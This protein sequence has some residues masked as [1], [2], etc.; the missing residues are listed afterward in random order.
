[1]A[2]DKLKFRIGIVSAVFAVCVLSLPVLA[3]DDAGDKGRTGGYIPMDWDFNVQMTDEDI[4]FEEARERIVDREDDKGKKS[5]LQILKVNEYTPR[6]EIPSNYPASG[7]SDTDALKTALQGKFPVLRNQAEFGTCWAHAS[8]AMAEFFGIEHHFTGY[9]KYDTDFSELYLALAIYEQRQNRKIGLSDEGGAITFTGNDKE[10]ID[11]GG[12]FTFA[13]QLLSKGFG[14]VNETV[15][16]YISSKGSSEFGGSGNLTDEE[17]YNIEH[18]NDKVVCHLT[19]LY[20]VDIGSDTGKNIVKEAIMQ[21]GIVGLSMYYPDSVGPY[22]RSFGNG[23]AF[24]YDGVI[25]KPSKPGTQTNHAVCIVGWD[26]D[27]PKSNFNEGRQPSGN[28]AWLIRNSWWSKFDSDFFTSSG[29]FWMSY[30]D[31]CLTDSGD[32]SKAVYIY[33]VTND[34]GIYDNV[35][36]YDKQIHGTSSL[37]GTNTHGELL[38]DLN[39]YS[40]NVFA[41]PDDVDESLKEVCIE[42][43]SATD[44]EIKIYTDIT[45]PNDPASGTLQN[46]ATTTGTLSFPGIYTIPLNNPVEL[47]LGTSFSVVVITKENSVCYEIDISSGQLS[48]TPGIKTG[49]SFYK[50][51]GV[52]WED[53]KN[54]A[55]GNFCISAHTKNV[56]THTLVAG[57]FTF[58]K[59]SVSTYDG[60]SHPAT[61]TTRVNAGTITVYYSEDGVEWTTD[62]PV[63]PGT[64]SVK[65]DAA[66]SEKVAGVSGLTDPGWTFT[67][68]KGKVTV[69]A[70]DKTV[71]QGKEMPSLTYSVSGFNG[72]PFSVKPVLSCT[73]SDTKTIGEYKIEASGGTFEHPERF[74]NEIEYEDGVLTI[75]EG[76]NP[77]EEGGKEDEKEVLEKQVYTD[78][79]GGSIS[80]IYNTESH[81][82]ETESGEQVLGVSDV[83]GNSFKAAGYQYTGKKITPGKNSLV[84]YKG[85]VYRF[86]TD[87]TVSFKRN[88]KIGS[89]DAVIKWKKTSDPYLEGEKKTTRGFEIK[90]REVTPEMVQI[91]NKGDKIK[92]ITVAA[93]G[94]TIKAT[95][96]DYYYTGTEADGFEITFTNNFN[97]KVKKKA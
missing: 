27:F 4:S 6:A 16:P 53:K 58:K 30:E 87:Y 35:Y 82:L 77:E 73:A 19:N 11:F 10:R 29:Y 2:F 39:W 14:Y 20:K 17:K 64:Y 40:A 96:K 86:K 43:D 85:V 59:P 25:V 21:N 18:Y 72:D 69:K 88:K 9:S 80:V 75:T 76:D 5:D 55:G 91:F 7:V 92:K 46:S 93:D 56:G 66:G 36:Y 57:D 50:Y 23:E 12:N 13:A 51:E 44:Y 62:A 63:L 38:H 89:A 34:V 68:G 78:P 54:D 97:G 24:Y 41:G 71:K 70:D 33:D 31:G 95:K 8:A 15:L 79:Y 94:L 28:G 32:N 74:E 1:M 22:I 45:D 81:T 49:Q 42:V 65:I 60:N 37:Y 61:L 90:P 67:I 83:S 48:V 84:I 26:D 47:P 3:A 52:D